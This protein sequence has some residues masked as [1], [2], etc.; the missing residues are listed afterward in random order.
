MQ[1]LPALRTPHIALMLHATHLVGRV[2]VFFHL[3]GLQLLLD[4][5]LLGAQ[6]AS[7]AVEFAQPWSGARR[8]LKDAEKTGKVSFSTSQNKAVFTP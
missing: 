6:T 8:Y 3:Q 4:R 5:P 2:M 1:R 7:R